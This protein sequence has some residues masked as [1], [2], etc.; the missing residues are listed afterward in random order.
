MFYSQFGEDKILT[1]IFNNEYKGNCIDI[2]ASNG[3]SGN[4]TYYFEK[5][6]WDCLCIEPIPTSF[7]MCKTIRKKCINCCVSDKNKDDVNFYICQL[8]DGNTDAISSLSIDTRLIKTHS[9]IIDKIIPIKVKCKTLTT[10]L[11]DIKFDENIDFISIDTENTELDVLKG[12]DFNKFTVKILI[13]ENNFN[14]DHHE[15]YLLEKNFVKFERT[16]VNDFYLNVNLDFSN[17]NNVFQENFINNMKE[18]SIISI[19][20][21]LVEN[22]PLSYLSG[23]KLGD[24][25]NQLSVICENYH[26]TGKKGILYIRDLE[27]IHDKFQNGVENIYKET[28]DFIIKQEYIED[29]KIYTNETY[30]I[31]LSTWREGNLNQNF[32]NIYKQ[33]YNVEW[34]SHKWLD[35][36]EINQEWKDVIVI[37]VTPYRFPSNETI[38]KFLKNINDNLAHC[39]FIGFNI[40]DYVTFVSQTKLNINFY[41]CKDLYEM[42]VIINSSKMAYLGLSAPA[43]FAN[44]LHKNHILMSC[45][46][47]IDN[48]LNNFKQ[49]TPH[50]LD[51][52]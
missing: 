48:Q 16:G 38:N 31:N 1:T 37:N 6:G 42:L 8:K 5:N 50:L 27:N 3:T 44:A 32:Y 30:D 51:M 23:G 26:K 39:F 34:A 52:Y 46:I 4:N 49:Y 41:K 15:K 19:R 43:T 10:I 29:Y 11:D 17:M 14:E 28:Y 13:I 18:K 33:F 24:F 2:G 36:I 45:G 40:N 22:K 21:S 35:N 12:I 25:V 20:Q 7:E 47:P 9:H